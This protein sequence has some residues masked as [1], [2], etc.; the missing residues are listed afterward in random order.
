MSV[1]SENLLTPNKTKRNGSVRL[2]GIALPNEHGS[3]SILLEPLV[4]AGTVAFTPATI[5]IT[6]L[7]IGG[8][9]MRQ[10]LRIWL[11]DRNAGRDL[12]QTAAARKY[13]A[14]YATIFGASACLRSRKEAAGI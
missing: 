7:F 8:F 3:W 1:I 9:L 11:A 13:T 4:A 5:W 6:L 2:R 10:P 14:I 12:P